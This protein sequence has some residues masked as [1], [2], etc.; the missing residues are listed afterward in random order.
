MTLKIPNFLTREPRSTSRSGGGGRFPD[1]SILSPKNLPVKYS[2]KMNVSHPSVFVRTTVSS[3]IRFLFFLAFLLM[4]QFWKPRRFSFID[5]EGWRWIA[6]TGV[7]ARGG[8]R[9]RLLARRD[10]C[11]VAGTLRRR[12][13]ADGDGDRGR[14]GEGPVPRGR[15][16][17]SVLWHRSQN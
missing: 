10:G 8:P 3:C 17:R 12:G 15:R 13:G 16:A 9:R 1:S 2:G 14:R 7:E 6:D 4:P 11:F 5:I